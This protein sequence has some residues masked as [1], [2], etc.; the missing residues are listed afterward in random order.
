[1]KKHPSLQS[2][3][4]LRE[5][6][7][8]E[9]AEP[10]EDGELSVDRIISEFMSDGQSDADVKEYAAPGSGN[11]AVKVPELPDDSSLAEF[12]ELIGETAP[13]R[14]PEPASGTGLES[15][16]DDRAAQNKQNDRTTRNDRAA[17]DEARG[18]QSAPIGREQNEPRR[19]DS[20]GREQ[21]GGRTTARAASEEQNGE[22]RTDNADERQSVAASYADGFSDS[23][24][25]EQISHDVS[26]AADSRDE[27]NRE[28][29]A[30]EASTYAEAQSGG[31]HDGAQA[32]KSAD[33]RQNAAEEQ[34]AA[35]GQAAEEQGGAAA[36]IA[37]SAGGTAGTAAAAGVGAAATGAATTGAAAS[38]AKKTL[39]FG[40]NFSETTDGLEPTYTTSDFYS[41]TME[42]TGRGKK[43]GAE[44]LKYDFADFS[45]ANYFTAAE[46]C[47]KKA[48]SFRF[49]SFLCFLAAA[50]C[51]YLTI[52]PSYK[53]YVPQM[54]S[55]VARPYISL[56][57]LIFAQIFSML[58]SCDIIAAGF[59]RLAKLRPTLD[60][61]AAVAST[62]VLL[63]AVSI[64][65]FPQWGGYLPYCA[66]SCA[67]L[68]M[69]LAARAQKYAALRKNFKTVCTSDS[70]CGIFVERQEDGELCAFKRPADRSEQLFD[71]IFDLDASEK[72]S[73]V[74]APIFLCAAPVFAALSSFG[75][76]CGQR[77][78]C[79]FA[80]ISSAALPFSAFISASLPRKKSADVLNSRGAAII[81]PD[82]PRTLS[83]CRRAAVGDEDIF[84]A[85]TT[86]VNGF[87]LVGTNNFEKVFTYTAGVLI[88]ADTG[89]KLLFGDLLKQQM[90]SPVQANSIIHY[91]GGI[92]AQINGDSVLVGTSGF[93]IRMGVRV[94]EG[95]EIKQGVFT[96][97]NSE[98][99]G[100]FALKYTAVPS[101]SVGLSLMLRRR[102][103][104]V[105]AVRDFNL[106][107]GMIEKKFKI[108]R[109]IS[110]YPDVNRR[111]AMSEYANDAP[112]AP[113][114]VMPFPSIRPFAETLTV[115]RSA[116][117]AIR[118]NIVFWCMASAAGL[119]LLTYLMRG[120][121][122]AA[123]APQNVLY[124]NL[125]WLVPTFLSSAASA[126]N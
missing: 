100:I 103:V 31:T 107:P 59:Y 119:I 52:A 55:Y 15:A 102:I 68:C 34:N 118:K 89:L 126:R 92:S 120:G 77:F 1:M 16:Q 57:V 121:E 91:E 36:D 19:Q 20:V 113:A 72:F 62:A 75:A 61:A 29:K 14:E 67:S 30:A 85:G 66:V 11:F 21:K 7:Q 79:A 82:I 8:A 116:Y 42:G 48:S 78:L 28:L 86:A 111:V 39:R 33:S 88:S 13:A 45:Q 47:A 6:I 125:L 64:V 105:L 58:L 123:A 114:A 26:E 93:L 101:A 96:A 32:E 27:R 104:P 74:F 54:L 97:I 10:T 117:K 109:G 18:E 106:T 69:A 4:S 12:Y 65:I 76:G 43:R 38:A 84:P 70:P 87:K 94:R 122:F 124:Y 44:P 60:S 112:D 99:V 115:A 108:K 41:G 49:R 71:A 5:Q 53:I 80:A 110:D 40:R 23:A 83:K 81:T 22:A 56:A 24:L 95:L 9:N 17:Q 37:A 46:M 3:D 50:L 2:E 73:F 98:L 25:R 90:L 63:H 35:D 51:A